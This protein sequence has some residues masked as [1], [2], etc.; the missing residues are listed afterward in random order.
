[1]IIGRGGF[2]KVWVVSLKNK[3]KY[4][5]L[6]EMS[7]RRIIH[8]RS[9]ESVM[10]EKNIL[11]ELKHN[12]IV[13]MKCAF[14]DRNNLYLAMDLLT[15]GDLRFHICYERVF[16]EQQTKFFAACIILGLKYIHKHKF[17]HR[18]M[19]PENLVFDEKG[20]LRITD[21]GIARKLKPENYKETSGTPGYMAPE[22]MCRQNYTQSIDFFALGVIVFECM[23]GRRPYN[24]R[25]RREIRDK[26]LSK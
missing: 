17:I 25:S 23:L 15:G 8:K 14:Q 19:K 5:A 20:F 11:Q 6:K 10:N 24:G 26:I 13:N 16:S 3:K 2:G 4:Y 9:V 1:M 21:F 18:D 7:K 22:V 12:F